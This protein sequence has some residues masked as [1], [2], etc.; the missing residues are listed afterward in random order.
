MRRFIYYFGWTMAIG[1]IMYVGATYQFQLKQEYMKNYNAQ[2]FVFFSTIFSIGI[3]M[4]LKL[5][6]LLIEMKENKQWTF[7]WATFIGIGLPSLAVCSMGVLL[8]TP[9]GESMFP[10]VP[11]IIYPGNS[12]IQT[13]AGVV[14]GFILLDSVKK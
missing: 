11:E 7:D 14:F 3:G 4:L 1:M 5:P 10:F 6:N 9:V 8:F 2:S 13:I 12:P